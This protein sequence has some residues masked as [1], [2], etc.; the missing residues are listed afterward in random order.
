[1]WIFTKDGYIDIKQHKDDPDKLLVRARVKGDL[2][3]IFPGC[4]VVEG[5]GVDYRFRTT[6]PRY[7]VA[8]YII[9]EIADMDYIEGFKTKA[10]SKRIP[11][12]LRIWE[13]LCDM[14][15]VLSGKA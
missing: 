12:Y 6:L 7:T 8:G 11:F 5:G 14:Q 9:R 13:T 15:D 1:M 2:E 10:D 3:K 4:V